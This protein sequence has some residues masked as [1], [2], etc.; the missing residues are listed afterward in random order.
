MRKAIM[1]IVGLA[2]L[3]LISHGAAALTIVTEQQVKNVCGSKL[4][5]G[6]VKGACVQGCEVKCGNTWCSYNCCKGKKCPVGEN[7]NAFTFSVVAPGDKIKVPRPVRLS[8][9]ARSTAGMPDRCQWCYAGCARW[10]WLCRIHCES[11]NGCPPLS[12]KPI[13]VR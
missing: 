8:L 9:M 5:K 7:C 1:F 3:A 2:V 13:F 6:C 12:P 10:N 11:R 4:Q